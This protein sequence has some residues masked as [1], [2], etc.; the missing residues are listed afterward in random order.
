MRGGHGRPPWAARTLPFTS[1]RDCAKWHSL[2]PRRGGSR[3]VWFSCCLYTGTIPW[4]NS[5]YDGSHMYFNAP[6]E[7]SPSPLSFKRQANSDGL[8]TAYYLEDAHNWRSE[9]HHGDPMEFER[10]ASSLPSR[11]AQSDGLAIASP[12]GAR[13]GEWQNRKARNLLRLST[14]PETQYYAEFQLGRPP[15]VSEGK[16]CRNSATYY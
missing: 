14:G 13:N 9:R 12:V 10:W 2:C 8:V 7:R 1:R 5:V 6:P 3:L 16:C 11:R 15:A 4:D